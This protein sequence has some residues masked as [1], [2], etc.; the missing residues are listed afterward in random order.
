[1]D[2]I[3]LRILGWGDYHGSSKLFYHNGTYKKDTRGVRV[4]RE[5]DVVTET[6]IG[7]KPFE[8]GGRDH[9]IQRI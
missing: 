6:D 5:A 4:K 9:P 3:K 2:K 8:D 1:M 7:V